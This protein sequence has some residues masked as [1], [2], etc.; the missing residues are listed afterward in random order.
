MK[1]SSVL[2]YGLA[3]LTVTLALAVM[4]ALRSMLTPTA[5]SLFL[6]C[7]RWFVS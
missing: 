6:P 3:S 1:A 7:I 4:A 2:R 5:F